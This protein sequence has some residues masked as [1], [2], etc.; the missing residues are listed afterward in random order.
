MVKRL[1]CLVLIAAVLT[2]GIVSLPRTA[3][4]TPALLV[5]W[6]NGAVTGGLARVEF[7]NR[8]APSLLLWGGAQEQDGIFITPNYLLENIQPG[9]AAILE[10]NLSGIELFLEKNNISTAVMLIPTACAIKQQEL[11][12]RAQIYNQKALIASAYGRLSGR[13]STVDVYTELFAAKDQ[14][15][16]YRTESNLTGLGG[17]YVYRSLAERLGLTVRPLAQF[18]VEHLPQDYY[19]D[20]YL[21]SRY[22][23]ARP[24]ILTLY[25]FSRYERQYQ[26]A[27]V[28]GGEVKYYYTLFPHH[29]ALFGQP[30]QVL[31]GGFGQRM[32]ISVASPY[33]ESLLVFADK[34]ALS[35]LPFLVVHYGNVTVVD[36]ESN[37][38]EQLSAL[39]VSQYD[40]VLFAYS[41][42]S[43]ISRPVCAAA[44]LLSS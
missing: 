12:A 37:S 10:A 7:L 41:V 11:P 25:R 16:Y 40:Q 15:T 33:E 26:L 36:L 23:G 38:F 14:Y 24:D 4:P 28:D 20:L 29:L 22:K 9:E 44:Q 17:Y 34:T 30:Q 18:E 39:D 19:G 13:V 5:S 27:H 32:D 8:L 35:Y 31:L 6:A 42:D 21:R 2:V 1:V 43:F 3:P